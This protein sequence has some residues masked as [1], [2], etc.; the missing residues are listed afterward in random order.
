MIAYVEPLSGAS[1]DM[2]LGA[3]LDVGLSSEALRDA[4]HTLPLPDWRLESRPVRRGAMGATQA[5]VVTEERDAPTRGLAEVLGMIDQGR[6]P[7][8][9]AGQARAIFT[10]LAECEAHVHRTS[11][12]EIHF[13]EVGAAD[14]IADICGVTAGLALLDVERLYCAPL[15]LN[16]GGWVAA[17][18]GRLPLP[19]PATLELLARAEAP[20]IPHPAQVELLTPTGAAILT[21]L[22]RFERP[23][24]RLRA[25][26]Y[27]AGGRTE[28]EPNVLRL[29]L[30]EPSEAAGDGESTERLNMLACNIDD[31]NPQWY[32]HLYELLLARGALDVTCVPALMKKGRP[33]QVLSVLCREADRSALSNLL[34]RETTTLGVRDHSVTRRAAARAMTS[35]D[36]AYGKVPVKLRLTDGRVTQ[37]I[38]EYDECRALAAT[39]G[40]AL[41]A[42]TMAAQAAAYPLLGSRFESEE[43]R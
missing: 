18:H 4:L 26:G 7:G 6:L 16:S 38:P 21:V 31:M 33:G 39:A 41:A 37:A 8:A 12:Q 40:V 42:V 23:A 24:M 29:T 43:N 35:V 9:A 25:A 11:M 32:G 14:A 20:T 19:A 34:L 36:T 17:A 27:G 10:R 2:L 28:P 15:P 3:L 5:L 1:G 30:G 13:H 22:A